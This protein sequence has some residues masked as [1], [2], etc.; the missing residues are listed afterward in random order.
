MIFF[1]ENVYK[2]DMKVLFKVFIG[3]EKRRFFTIDAICFKELYPEL[4]YQDVV[5]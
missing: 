5:G 2:K 3:Y 1:T 4:P